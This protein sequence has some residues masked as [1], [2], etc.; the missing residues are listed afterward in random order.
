[1]VYPNGM[2]ISIFDHFNSVHLIDLLRFMVYL[3]ENARIF[4]T[5]NYV[6]SNLTWKTALRNIMK[7]GW[8]AILS[9]KY[10]DE[11]RKNLNLELNFKNKTALD[12]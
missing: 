5:K 1:M 7:N 9:D 11:L 8:R 2:E 10:I 6:Y 12:F 4:E 3:S